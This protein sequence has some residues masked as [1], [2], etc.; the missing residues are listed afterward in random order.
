MIHLILLT[1][2]V[3]SSAATDRK[4]EARTISSISPCCEKQSLDEETYT[5][6]EEHVDTSEY[7][8]DSH[9]VY[10][11]AGSP[12]S[13]F[14]MA[15]RG[16]LSATCLNE[17][18]QVKAADIE[19]QSRDG[20]S[21]GCRETSD[22]PVSYDKQFIGAWVW[23]ELPPNGNLPAF[24]CAGPSQ[25]YLSGSQGSAPAGQGWP[26]GTIIVMPGCT[27]YGWGTYGWKGVPKVIE[28]G[29]RRLYVPP[30]YFGSVT[31][32]NNVGCYL[33]YRVDCTQQYPNCAP[34]TNWKVIAEFDNTGSE[35]PATFAYKK[36]V[37]TTWSDSVTKSLS[38]SATV[39]AEISAGIDDLLSAKLSA[40]LTTGITYSSTSTN[41]G[42]TS[43]EIDVQVQVDGGKKVR[44]EQNIAHCG[45]STFNTQLIRVV[46]IKTCDPGWTNFRSSCYKPFKEELTFK[47]AEDKCV[48][49]GGHVSSIQSDEEN[50]FVEKLG[51]SKLWVGAT[52]TGSEWKWADGYCGGYF[53]WYTG[54]P[55]DPNKE[56]CIA[57]WTDRQSKWNDVLC[58]LTYSFV[59]KKSL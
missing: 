38:V 21:V 19:G 34:E 18:K 46:E 4:S 48:C 23:R 35:I 40:S 52:W 8:C 11:K 28:G 47:A 53:N 3:V 50:A 12:G 43:K 41:G 39:S 59:C 25:Y 42:S 54:E 58:T 26:A 37:G 7:G 24:S 55:N 36:T 1:L 29:Q 44:Y 33:S 13:R 17:G 49:E 9:C 56:P 27:F 15:D 57:L 45:G 2:T 32:G 16:N 14:C 31:C 22:L 30:N 20:N 51:G 10:E 6:V 5:L